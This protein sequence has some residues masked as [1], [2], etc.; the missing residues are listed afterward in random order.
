MKA[1]NTEKCPICDG[2]GKIPYQLSFDL[3]FIFGYMFN[4]KDKF[5]LTAPKEVVIK[6][7]N[8]IKEYKSNANPESNS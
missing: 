1:K 8:R 6:I 2:K 4:L 7:Y 3:G 5:K